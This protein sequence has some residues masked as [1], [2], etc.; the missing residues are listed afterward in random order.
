M[1]R[2]DQAGFEEGDMHIEGSHLLSEAFTEAFHREFTGRV[3]TNAHRSHASAH[4]TGQDNTPLTRLAHDRQHRFGDGHH[5][6]KIYIENLPDF[7]EDKILKEAAQPHA[8]E[9]NQTI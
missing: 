7:V 6:E 8:S 5:S 2:E 3:T 4:R 1:R 9:L